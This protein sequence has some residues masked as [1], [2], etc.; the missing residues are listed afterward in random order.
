MWAYHYA[1]LSYA[2]QHRNFPSYQD[3]HH[4]PDDVYEEQT[5]SNKFIFHKLNRI[6]LP[7]YFCFRNYAT[8]GHDHKESLGF[9]V[10]QPSGKV[11]N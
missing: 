3:N 9:F 2:T 6:V 1:Q 8:M 11:M 10:T 7:N 4:F 5:E